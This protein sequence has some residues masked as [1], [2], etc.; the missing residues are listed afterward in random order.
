MGED[1]KLTRCPYRDVCE[2]PGYDKDDGEWIPVEGFIL[3]DDGILCL[4]WDI[5]LPR[6]K[7]SKLNTPEGRHESD[8]AASADKLDNATKKYNKSEN[9]KRAQERYAAS[10]RGQAATQRFAQTE[11]AKLI[12]QKYQQTPK[13]QASLLARRGLVKDFRKVAK[14]LRDNPGKSPADYPGD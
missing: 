2:C 12:V 10:P 14:W 9:R 13:G 1:I 4:D 8:A 6:S 5:V 3:Q 7:I 11:K